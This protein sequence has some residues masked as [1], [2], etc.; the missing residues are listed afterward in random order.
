MNMRMKKIVFLIFISFFLLTVVHPTYAQTPAS[1]RDESTRGGPTPDPCSPDA[2]LSA[3]CPVRYDSTNTVI[4]REKTWVSGLLESIAN[5]L[6]VQF[7]WAGSLRPSNDTYKIGSEKF[8]NYS[9]QILQSSENDLKPAALQVI[10]TPDLQPK[11]FTMTSVVCAKDPDTGKITQISSSDRIEA[12]DI[13]G[14]TQAIEG[15][16]QLDSYVAGYTQV[17]QD[18]NLKNVVVSTS[19]VACDTEESGQS[20]KQT[21]V[22]TQNQNTYSG[23]T[24]VIK[25]F[26]SLVHL[27]ITK[28]KGLFQAEVT[29]TAQI[30][31]KA[32]TPWMHY[33]LCLF[34]GCTANDVSSVTY[35]TNKEQVVGAGGAVAAMYKPAEIDDTYKSELNAATDQE[36]TITGA[37]NQSEQKA[38][39]AVN[40]GQA[41]ITAAGDYM[42]CTLMPA[43]YQATAMPGDECNKNWVNAAAGST[44]AGGWNCSTNVGDQSVAGLHTDGGQRYADTVWGSC[45]SGKEN[46][47]KLCKNDVIVRAKK[48]CIDP[49][50][51][52]AIWLH[53]SGASNYICGQQ[54]SGGKAQDF[55]INVSS[56]A[57][58][59][60]QQIDR[61]LL[62]PGSYA[63]RCP[64]TLKDFVALYWFGNGCYNTQSASNKTKIDGYIGELQLI[65]ATI[66]PG[67]SLPTWPGGC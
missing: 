4:P 44:T 39:T 3:P 51:A 66:A 48:A 21:A 24:S 37:G 23:E 53:E 20:V 30:Q 58:N 35:D 29:Q 12:K 19:N 10:T 14:L 38:A 55:G 57:E 5:G 63:S 2:P 52:L 32:V 41:R 15:A 25:T 6:H 9:Q 13:P 8:T 61:F 36:W 60:S 45:T 17:S 62:L 11:P 47:W 42:N 43:D 64:K 50:F 54:L 67:V 27:I 59:F 56:I 40:F 26:V 46:A 1:T 31:G 65:Y 16:R 34:A 22:T 49:I 18:Y 28:M 33:A 7:D